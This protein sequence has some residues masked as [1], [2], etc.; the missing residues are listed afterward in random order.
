M[1]VFLPFLQFLV[2][3]G[4]RKKYMKFNKRRKVLNKQQNNSSLIFGDIPKIPTQKPRIVQ[5][6]NM[7]STDYLLIFEKQILQVINHG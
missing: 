7:Y 4:D 3:Q 6:F 5:N 2:W 1:S